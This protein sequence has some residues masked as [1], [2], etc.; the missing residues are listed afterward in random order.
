MYANRSHR[1]QTLNRGTTGNS[2]R[3]LRI[4]YGFVF[5]LCV[6]VPAILPV[7]AATSDVS[8]RSTT[9]Y[10]MTR[11]VLIPA[12]TFRMGDITGT[13]HKRERPIHQINI[14]RSFLIGRTEVTQAQ[15]EAVMGKNPSHFKGPS[16]PVESVSWYDAVEFCNALSKL[17]GLTPCYSGSGADIVCDFSANGYRLPTEAEW[18]YAA[19][20]GTETDFNTGNMTHEKAEPLDPAMDLAGWYEGNAGMKSHAVEL[21]KPNA[22]GLHDMH[23]N[24]REWCWDFY[25]SDYYESRPAKDPHGP[26]KGPRRVLRGG[27]WFDIAKNC[28]SAVRLASMPAF[29]DYYNGFRVVRTY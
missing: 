7:Q 16:L 23:G 17:E 29:T 11:M 6:F 1:L 8:S 9:G 15:F 3:G 22:F 18:E 27:G 14:S 21:K 20:G 13:G 25:S 10:D 12:G 26:A 24:V 2:G 4:L 28:R 5:V 19:R